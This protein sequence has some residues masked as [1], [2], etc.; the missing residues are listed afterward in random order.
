MQ[1]QT[2][3]VVGILRFQKW[4]D[5]D[6]LGFQIVDIYVFLAW[7]LLGLLFEK[8]GKIFSNLLVT[9][10][11]NKICLEATESDKHFSLTRYG[12]NYSSKKVLW[13]RS[14]KLSLRK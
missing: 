13:Y 10:T 4:F 8:L 9:L 11:E 6:I 14:L 2:W 3:F 5:V 1:F 12:V 7:R